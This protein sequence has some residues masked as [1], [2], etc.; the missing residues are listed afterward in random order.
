MQ[1]EL[2]LAVLVV[3]AIVEGPG[4]PVGQ[5]EFDYGYLCAHLMSVLDLM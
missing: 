2:P 4:G 5:S 1:K 3:V